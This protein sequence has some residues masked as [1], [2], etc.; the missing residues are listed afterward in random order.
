VSPSIEHV[1]AAAEQL[2][3]VVIRTPLI[4]LHAPDDD[5]DLLLKLETCQPIG[6]FKVR[7]VFHA[8]ASLSD[9]ARNAGL[10]TVSAGNTAQALAWCGRR[11]GVAATSLMPDTAPRTKVNAV[12]A[13][14]GTPELVPVAEVF[15]FLKQDGWRDRREAFV[16]PW[17]DPTLHTG[18]ATIALELLEDRADLDT[19]YVP[20][21]G[22]GLLGGVGPALKQL[23]P[24]LRI[25]A[26]EPAGCP[27]LHSS[28]AAGRPVEVD[29]KTCCDGVAVPYITDQMFPILRDIVD[30]AVLVSEDDVLD[31][32][33][34]L[35]LH[36]RVVVEPSG[37]LALA[38]ALA[39]PAAHRGVT[40]CLVTGGSVDRDK[41]VAILGRASRPDQGI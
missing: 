14:G 33:Q 1:R 34:R 39:T 11:F 17:T 24:S 6:S 22:G 37:A 23:K 21:G 35:A 9:H 31:T 8:V 7:G 19:V 16:H 28:L 30:D 5:A 41:L 38:A 2:R 32:A 27:S 26:V 20:V 3:G 13:L 40:C 29:C 18:H 12:K 10:L 15:R 4:P 25:V 36:E